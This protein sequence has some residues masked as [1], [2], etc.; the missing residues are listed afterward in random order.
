MILRLIEFNERCFDAKY[1]F[2]TF[3]ANEYLQNLEK[4]LHLLRGEFPYYSM[5]P[6]KNCF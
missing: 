5:S 4:E 6:L 2:L 3:N 1:Q